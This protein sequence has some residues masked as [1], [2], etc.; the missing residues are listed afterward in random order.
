MGNFQGTHYYTEDLKAQSEIREYPPALNSQLMFLT[1]IQCLQGKIINNMWKV[2]VSRLE[3]R[4]TQNHSPS[5]KGC[6]ILQH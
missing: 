3:W 6:P 5:G 1:A 4:W 2:S